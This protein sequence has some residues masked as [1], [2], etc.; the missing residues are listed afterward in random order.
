MNSIRS[1]NVLKL[2]I[3]SFYKPISEIKDNRQSHEGKKQSN[4]TTTQIISQGNLVAQNTSI[5]YCIL[6]MES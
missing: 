6:T 1:R 5:F 4:Q 2:D 3:E